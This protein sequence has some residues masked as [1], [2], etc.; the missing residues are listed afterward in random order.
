MLN[1]MIWI[2]VFTLH[3]SHWN[4]SFNPCIS[5]DQGIVNILPQTNISFLDSNSVS[6]SNIQD[7]CAI[8]TIMT[9]MS[10]SIITAQLV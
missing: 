8:A 1:I 4:Q 6:A 9:Q 5:L 3:R 7:Q 10:S 2:D